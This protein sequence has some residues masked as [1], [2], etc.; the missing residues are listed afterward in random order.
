MERVSALIPAGRE[1]DNIKEAIESLLWADEVL[2]VVDEESDDGTYEI[3]A[4]FGGKVRV[5]KHEYIYS[6]KQK[7]WAIPQAKNDW[8]F[9]MDAD[10]RPDE[11]LIKSIK[12]TLKAPKHDAY[13]VK[14]RNI[15][16]GKVLKYGGLSNDKVIRLFKRN[17]RYEDKRVHAE[18]VGYKSLGLLEGFLVHQTFKDW[19]SY[20]FKLNRYSKW[21]A[22][23]AFLN[24]QKANFINL[25]LRPIHRF[26]KQYLFRFG[27]LDGMEG[28]INALLSSYA[29]FLKYSIL[30]EI[31]KKKDKI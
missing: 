23:Q 24:G 22:E 7:N 25:F 17:L 12:E 6:A 16:L 15:F 27:F 9:L 31:E 19:D 14:R 26:L 2:V 11:K 29:V 13:E 8:I 10:E 5:L 28:L 30:F 18:I 3:A 4:S 20:L 1:K 21:G